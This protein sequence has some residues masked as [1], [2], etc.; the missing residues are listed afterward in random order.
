[1]GIAF[2]L[3]FTVILVILREALRI[4]KIVTKPLLPYMPDLGGGGVGTATLLGAGFL[5]LLCW[6]ASYMATTGKGR[7]AEA[8]LEQYLLQF[9]PG[10]SLIRTL[11]HDMAGRQESAEMVPVMARIEDAWQWG[12]ITDTLESGLLS[13][14]VPSVPTISEG[15]I[16]FLT[17][18]RVKRITVPSQKLYHNVRRFGRGS[19]QILSGQI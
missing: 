19:R 4:A 9:I 3:P 12:F 14:F 15:T 13:V 2:L 18:D 7:R 17:E 8:W 10:Y 6:S 5:V 1:M 16:Y 11:L